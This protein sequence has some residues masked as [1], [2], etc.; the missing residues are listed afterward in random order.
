LYFE[1]SAIGIDNIGLGRR[2]INANPAYRHI[3]IS[4]VISL[5]RFFTNPAVP[6]EF[7]A[8]FIHLYFDLAW[9]GI[10]SGTAMSF[11]TIYAARLGGSGFQIG[12]LAATSAFVNLILAIPASQIFQKRP[13]GRTVF[14]SS[15]LYRIGYLA[16]IPL[17]WLFTNQGQ[18]WALIAITLL[19]G[20]PLTVQ[21]IGFNALFAAAV[22]LEWRASVAGTR[23]LAYSVTYMLSALGAGWLLVHL[24]FPVGYQVVF[25]IGG[26]AAL[27]SSAHLFFVRIPPSVPITPDLPASPEPAGH[28]KP[29]VRSLWQSSLRLDIWRT[30]FAGVLLAMLGLHLTQ[31]LAIPLFPLFSVNVLHLT[32]QNIGVGTALYYMT[33]ML[34]STQLNRIVRRLG[35]RKVTGLGFMIMSFYAGLMPFAHSAYGYYFISIIGG[36]SWA[37]MGSAYMNYVLES[38]PEN[39]RPAHLAWYNIVL[40]ASI[41]V[42]SLVGPLIAGFIG[43]AAALFVAGVVRLL[44]GYALFKGAYARRRIQADSS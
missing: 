42:G 34:G 11:L 16:W 36:F 43:L 27:M 1:T 21:A 6:R 35:H 20:I 19:M 13:V 2:I 28:M 33:S 26:F 29:S 7:R 32:D 30:P 23:N 17:P 22:P 8:N 41:L 31:Y 40:S 44:A 9:F 39:D 10:L 24:V 14:W 3:I 12:L 37:L 5:R 4:H 15:M 25:G 38:I 18:I